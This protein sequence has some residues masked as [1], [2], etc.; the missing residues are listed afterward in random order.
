MVL[1]Q[2]EE[3]RIQEELQ[4]DAQKQRKQ[5]FGDAQKQAIDQKQRML[6]EQRK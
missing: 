1:R 5:M 6:Q 2:M 3:K 4:K